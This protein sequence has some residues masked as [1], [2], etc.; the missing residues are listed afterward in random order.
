MN[1]DMALSKNMPCVLFST[2]H[3]FNNC[4]IDDMQHGDLGD[5]DFKRMGLNDISARVD[6]F[7]LIEFDSFSAFQSS[8]FTFSEPTPIGR[9]ISRQQC[10]NILFDEMK[11]L[12]TIF[13]RGKYA[14]I[15][16]EL[17][18]HFHYGN[19]LPW[20]STSLDSA[21]KE[22][23]EGIGTNDALRT[24]IE[25]IDNHL[26]YRGMSNIDF[27]FI[28]KIGNKI[29]RTRLAKFIRF[30]DKFNG[31]GVSVHDVYAQ[32]ISLIN[33]QRYAMSW[34]ALLYFKGQDHFGLG[35]E[36]I[37]DTIYKN[38]RFFRIWFLLQHHKDY[39]YKPF[40]TNFSAHIHVRGG[41]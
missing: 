7:N 20:Q 41:M 4:Y 10:A 3:R 23:V 26:I 19:G 13:S 27:D 12:S 14:H 5:D 29:N 32:E 37:N 17:I 11:Q 18:D 30:E 1:I 21:Y 15:I 9:K 40:L 16:H 25:M 35:K 39:A 33:F 2:F 8:T 24:I 22:I 28:T 38:F 36:D 31:L 6:P 34:S